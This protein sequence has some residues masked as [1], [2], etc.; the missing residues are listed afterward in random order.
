MADSAS[1]ATTTS[2]FSI[3]LQAARPKT[4]WAG[5]T[6]V[7][8][9][10][11]LA[12]GD[13]LFHTTAAV[14]ALLAALALQ[15]AAN[16]ANDLYDF[17]HG[18]DTMERIGP[19]R[20]T[21]AGL[22]SPTAMRNALVAVLGVAFAFGIYLVVRGGW[23]IVAIGLSS[24]VATVLY[25]GGPRPYGHLG[26]G[27]LFVFIF[28]GV[29][30]VCGT[31]YVQ[32]LTLTTTAIVLSLPMGFLSVAVL[33]VN[34]LRDIDTDRQSGKRTLAVRLGRA[35]GRWEF[36]I[37]LVLAAVIPPLMVLLQLGGYG[38]LL[39]SAAILASIPLIRTVCRST[40]GPVLNRA[41]AATARLQLI[42]GL[43]IAI[44]INL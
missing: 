10:S 43:L 37:L 6:P 42:Y 7:I 38:V 40:D 26:L 18:V 20:V 34:N 32:S 5:V 13:G 1:S 41:L 44:G 22:V 35:G 3:W 33:V 2:A 23:P 11:S 8:V 21:Q 39:G 19:L 12:W 15:V 30:A 25:T 14:A 36:V 31:Y 17:K 4:L 28:F 27:E 9:G 29:L 24:I 16:F